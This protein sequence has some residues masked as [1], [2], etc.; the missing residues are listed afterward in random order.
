M[1]IARK[2][3]YYAYNMLYCTPF[4]QP[5]LIF[6]RI[7]L[8]KFITLHVIVSRFISAS[9]FERADSTTQPHGPTVFALKTLNKIFSN[10]Q[11]N[12]THITIICD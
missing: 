3:F 10:S 6:T 4:V 9:S 8:A 7:Y 1:K 11:K 12:H 2:D 5:F